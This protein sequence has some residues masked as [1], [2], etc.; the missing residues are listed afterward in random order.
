MKTDSQPSSELKDQWHADPNNWSLGLFY[1]N[2]ADKRLFPPKKMKAMG[3]TI[4]FANPLS[5][6]LHFIL[7][8]I[9]IGLIIF[10]R[11]N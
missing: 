4:N 8:A 5:V 7:F 2:K 6:G 9:A 10:L 11:D 3:W 1:F